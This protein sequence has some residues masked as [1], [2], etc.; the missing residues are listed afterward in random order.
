MKHN[1]NDKNYIIV[2]EFLQLENKSTIFACGDIIETKEEKLAQLAN[3]H[4]E[5]ILTNIKRL[6]SR[7]SLIKY[8]PN[9]TPAVFVSM[10]KN[11]AI[12]LQGNNVLSGV[13]NPIKISE[14][15]F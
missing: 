15:H 8:V 10:G 7:Q 12:L 4:A 5:N 6:E 13:R 3:A 11:K 1:L 14:F 2:N 9:F